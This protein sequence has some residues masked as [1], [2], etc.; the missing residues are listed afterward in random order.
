MI[1]KLVED[2]L[3]NAGERGFETPFAQLLAAEGHRI[4]QGPLHHPIEHGKD[5]VSIDP[6]G[7]VCAFQLK[8]PNLVDLKDLEDIQGQLFALASTAISH[9]GIG[10]PRR[11]D[12]V[13][14]VTS[15]TLTYAVRDRLEQFNVSNIQYHFP[16]IEP[17]EREQLVFRFIA[18]HG[19]YLPQALP[20]IKTLLELYYADPTTLFHPKAFAEY[21]TKLL[22]FSVAKPSPLEC[23]RAI[24]SAALVTTYAAASWTKADN[25]LC[26]AQAWLTFCVTVLRLAAVFDLE[27]AAWRGPYDIALHAAR[28]SL[29]SLAREAAESQDLVVPHMMEGLVYPSRAVLIC[30]FLS[31]YLLS[32]RT[33]GHVESDLLE[34]VRTAIVR[35]KTY[36]KL[37][38]ESAIPAF[39]ELACALGQVGEFF[40]GETM[41]LALVANLSVSNRRHSESALADPYH[42]LEQI[43]MSM[44]GTE[45]D[46]EEEEFDGRSYML[47]VAI[48]WLARRLWR[49]TLARM[50]PDITQVEFMEFQPSSPDKY[51]APK[52][53]EG[54]LRAW[55]SPLPQ[56]WAALLSESRRSDYSAL[57]ILLRQRR[58]LIPYLPLLFPYRLTAT[59][60]AAI[61]ALT[62][63]PNTQDIV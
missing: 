63:D 61:D 3:V 36:I 62:G 45:S 30:G 50:W 24:A 9:A 53:D 39:M 25:H 16:P 26:V 35:E 13:F 34:R 47:H 12:R 48:E 32:E 23:R 6:S 27:E 51:L 1:A 49:Q 44:L 8:G 10:I 5:I 28:S 56:S 31:A 2:W 20:D 22:P 19:T 55:F 41:M 58:E 60:A 37:V 42:D 54:T 18:A 17:V 7:N 52:D 11:P 40:A 14:L 21:L 43:H 38:G 59:L 4:L 29:A 33:L 46:L 15:S 57:P